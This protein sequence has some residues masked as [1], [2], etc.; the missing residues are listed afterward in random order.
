MTHLVRCHAG[1][2]HENEAKARVE[3][4]VLHKVCLYQ[5]SSLLVQLHRLAR[6]VGM[7]AGTCL[8]SAQHGAVTHVRA[9]HRTRRREMREREAVAAQ[10]RRPTTA[11]VRVRFPE[12]VCL[13]GMF[14][15]REPL[16]ALHSWLADSLRSPG[17]TYDLVE[18]GRSKLQATGSVGDAGLAPA[19][20]LNLR[21]TGDS[22]HMF[23]GMSLLSDV[24]LRQTRARY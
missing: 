20:V 9:P 21:P 3:R 2:V 8:V 19:C 1:G 22:V 15:V 18:P 10:G 7:R 16:S 13:Q 12:G 17:I 24:M 11:T 5:A 23:R 6:T 14:G 4:T